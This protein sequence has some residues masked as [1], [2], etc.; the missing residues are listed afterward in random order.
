MNPQCDKHLHPLADEYD[1]LYYINK[2]TLICHLRV[3]CLTAITSKDFRQPMLTFI[4]VWFK[5]SSYA[6]YC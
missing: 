6:I 2:T 4:P 3:E 1:H 5:V